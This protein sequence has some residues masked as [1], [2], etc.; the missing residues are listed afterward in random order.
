MSDAES[1]FVTLGCLLVFVVRMWAEAPQ[2]LLILLFIGTQV[3]HQPRA[4]NRSRNSIF[5][6]TRE[7][8]GERTLYG[9]VWCH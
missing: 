7:G 3:I 1:A 2:Q 8:R 4:S 6:T 9:C 5:G